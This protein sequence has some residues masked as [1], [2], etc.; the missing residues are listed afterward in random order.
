METVPEGTGVGVAVASADVVSSALA[1]PRTEA[2]VDSEVVVAAVLSTS[3]AVVV[4]SVV[5]SLV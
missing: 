2:D 1:T 4:A 5:V 3:A